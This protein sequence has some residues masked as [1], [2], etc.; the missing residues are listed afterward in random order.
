MTPNDLIKLASRNARQNFLW[1]FSPEHKVE[2][3]KQVRDELHLS[4]KDKVIMDTCGGFEVITGNNSVVYFHKGIEHHALKGIELDGCVIEDF[5]KQ[6]I[7]VLHD[8]LYP[9]VVA[10]DGWIIGTYFKG[11]PLELDVVVRH[12][13]LKPFIADIESHHEKD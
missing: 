12:A 3:F 11:Q 6:D 10:R 9:A 4:P 7:S 2:D 1:V 8:L 5:A 13:A